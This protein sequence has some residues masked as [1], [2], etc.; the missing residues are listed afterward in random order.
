MMCLYWF[1]VEELEKH[2][3]KCDIKLP[4]LSRIDIDQIKQ[5][6]K[7]RLPNNAN[8]MHANAF[9]TLEPANNL[10]VNVLKENVGLL[11]RKK[12][13]SSNASAY[14]STVELRAQQNNVEHN[15]RNDLKS[16]F[17]ML[18]NKIPELLTLERVP[19]ITILNKAIEYV[20]SLQTTEQLLLRELEYQR[21]INEHLVCRAELFK[22]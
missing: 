20:Q 21:K 3:W 4:C 5:T 10:Q 7:F 1:S 9:R 13:Y 2:L 22:V 19:N 17:V 8:I 16:S 15:R 11:Q 14:C 18:K 6:S 12:K